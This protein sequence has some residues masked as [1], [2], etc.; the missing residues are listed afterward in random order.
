MIPVQPSTTTLLWLCG[1]VLVPAA[2]WCCTIFYQLRQRQS[3]DRYRLENVIKDNTSA[4]R[5]VAHYIRW[6]IEKTTGEKPPPPMP[7]V[8]EKR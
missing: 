1:I 7:A 3:V 5:E 6:M 4:M 2:I 8:M